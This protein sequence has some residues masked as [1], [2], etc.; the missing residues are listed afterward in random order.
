MKIA[1]IGY[2]KMGK[3]I[4]QVAIERGHEVV[5]KIND[6]NLSDFTTANLKKADMAI[7]FSQPEAA[8]Q[9]V[10]KCFDAGISVV[11]GTTGWNEKLPE[12]KKICIEKKQAF[13]YSPNYSV[14]VNMFFEIN[15]KLASMVAHFSQYDQIWITEAHHT[16]KKDVPSGT[17][18]KLA[19]DIL[20]QIKRLSKWKSYY[21]THLM[22]DEEEMDVTILPVNSI[23]IS[24]V[25]GI[26]EI[27]YESEEDCIEI[28]HQAKSRWGFA[29]GAVMAAEF[30]IG[31]K[32]IFG[33]KDLLGL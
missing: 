27:T 16:E 9:N 13:F 5:L 12:A 20:E 3:A 30:A 8:F 22:S 26:H 7:E 31:K 23:R 6:R 17:A 21:S 10:S 32:G 33:M 11:S 24:D 19:E 4:E 15:K 18:I 1:L 29:K 14:G 25:A 2:G 28:V